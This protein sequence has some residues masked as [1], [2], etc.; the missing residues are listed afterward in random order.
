MDICTC[1]RLKESNPDCDTFGCRDEYESKL[2]SECGGAGGFQ[3]YLGH[4]NMESEM[5]SECG[6]SGVAIGQ[7]GYWIP[8]LREP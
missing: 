6:G 2:C 3:T 7:A 5:C 1:V 8:G 4:G